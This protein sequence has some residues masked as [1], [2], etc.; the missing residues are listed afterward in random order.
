MRN[1]IQETKQRFAAA[2]NYSRKEKNICKQ[3]SSQA[4]AYTQVLVHSIYQK[5]PQKA[6][7]NNIS[8]HKKP[9]WNVIHAARDKKHTSS[10]SLPITGR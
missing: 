10:F 6:I 8:I 2:Y 3:V 9:E 1:Y 5:I 7:L 4:R